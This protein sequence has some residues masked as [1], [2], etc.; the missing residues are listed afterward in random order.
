MSIFTLPGLFSSFYPSSDKS[1]TLNLKQEGY[2]SLACFKA[3]RQ[4]EKD[5]LQGGGLNGNKKY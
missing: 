2:I 3:L 4:N 1:F 5:E